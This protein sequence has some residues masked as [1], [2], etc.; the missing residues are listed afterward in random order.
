[1]SVRK[2]GSV[3]ENPDHLDYDN[4]D[5]ITEDD[6]KYYNPLDLSESM[7]KDGVFDEHEG[8]LDREIDNAM[9]RRARRRR[10]NSIP[11]RRAMPIIPLQR[12]IRMRRA[13]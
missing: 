11:P 2:K 3:P 6:M 1:M 8:E 10:K 4:E 7:P 13:R 5:L 12:P 9:A